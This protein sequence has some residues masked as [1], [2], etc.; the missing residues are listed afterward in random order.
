MPVEMVGFMTSPLA[1]KLKVPIKVAST[2]LKNLK[3]EDYVA[4]IYASTR[5]LPEPIWCHGKNQ[6]QAARSVVGQKT[7]K[8]PT[9]W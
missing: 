7:L 2:I 9:Q 4:E 1:K 5:C 8:S 3:R 6:L